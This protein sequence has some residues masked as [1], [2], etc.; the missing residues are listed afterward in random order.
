V[1]PVLHA[2]TVAA[3]TRAYASVRHW[4]AQVPAGLLQMLTPEEVVSKLRL[5]RCFPPPSLPPPT[6][7]RASTEAHTCTHTST[8][9][10]THKCTRTH[11]RS[12]THERAHARTLARARAHTHTQARAR[13]HTHTD[14]CSRART[15][16]ETRGLQVR[17][18]LRVLAYALVCGSGCAAGCG[19]GRA[20]RHTR[21]RD[22]RERTGG[23]LRA[24]T[25]A[26]A[27]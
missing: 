27:G 25:R 1:S 4:P 14:A 24:L 22:A 21:A 26:R 5:P 6:R 3:R 11:A 15:H 2:R 19:G 10:Q 13:A 18:G 7:T 20:R 9:A 17:P 12:H 23:S 8:H 16:R